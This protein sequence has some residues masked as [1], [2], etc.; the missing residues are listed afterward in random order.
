MTTPVLDQSPDAPQGFTVEI[1]DYLTAEQPEHNFLVNTPH[2]VGDKTFEHALRDAIIHCGLG[3]RPG[4]PVLK[5]YSD[6]DQALI[7]QAFINFKST[8]IENPIYQASADYSNVPEKELLDDL[9]I[10]G[11]SAKIIKE[12]NARATHDSGLIGRLLFFSEAL[13]RQGSIYDWLNLNKIESTDDV[14]EYINLIKMIALDK[15]RE[16]DKTKFIPHFKNYVTEYHK[17]LKDAVILGFLKNPG[18]YPAIHEK[19]SAFQPLMWAISS[20]TDL[21]STFGGGLIFYLSDYVDYNIE[22]ISGAIGRRGVP[23]N[24]DKTLGFWQVFGD[25]IEKLIFSTAEY[26]VSKEECELL[27]DTFLKLA[28]PALQHHDL[29]E[30]TPFE[31]LV[32]REDLP[33]LILKK[34]L[35]DGRKNGIYL[36]KEI[37]SARG[38][39]LRKFSIASDY[40]SMQS[41]IE[42]SPTDVAD[43]FLAKDL[44]L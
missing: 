37:L 17:S 34:I 32:A 28:R 19:S 15:T 3:I 44:G 23:K 1:I 8:I 29:E 24:D 4:K 2:Q 6:V 26:G 16:I 25:K 10:Y 9:K 39:E 13:G 12:L 5:K 18:A 27:L 11:S 31:K 35:S 40:F 36:D 20:I 30:L 7:I 42:A 14:D 38:D 21:K 33:F 22:S 43:H 41:F